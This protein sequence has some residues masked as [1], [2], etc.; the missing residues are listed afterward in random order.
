LRS[1]Y[2]SS[3]GGGASAETSLVLLIA[4]DYTVTVGAGGTGVV[5]SGG[6]ALN[7][8]NSVFSTI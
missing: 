6:S 5:S 4:S 1:S 7:G 3:S 2:G 8:S